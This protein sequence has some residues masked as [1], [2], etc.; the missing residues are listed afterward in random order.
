MIAA[1]GPSGRALLARFLA[2]RPLLAFDIDGTL[3]PIVPTPDAA[4]IPEP[5]QQR[6][7][8]LCT[9]ASVAIVTGRSRA[10]AERLC[11]FAPAYILGNHGIEG[12][13]GYES[14]TSALADLAARW[15]TTLDTPALRESGVL[16]ED[17]RYSLSLH[18]RHAP[19]YSRARALIAAR[20][21]A[22]SPAPL[23]IDGKC[24]VNVLPPG[25][26]TKGD[27]LRELLAV[28][29]VPTALYAGDDDTDEHVFELPR[30]QVL[31]IRVG[32]RPATGATLY[33]DTPADMVPLLDAV[34]ADWPG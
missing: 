25:A 7:A 1:L 26:I 33:V 14:R 18:Y 19:D 12:L 10:D 13:P 15:R 6:L 2:A 32:V 3:A 20:L 8:T 34:L 16:V 22:L 31:G 24:V 21:A 23:V 11:A 4:R 9:R 5:L 28:S 27:A 30:E 29:G 17:K